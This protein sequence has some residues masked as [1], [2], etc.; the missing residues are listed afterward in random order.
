MFEAISDKVK[1]MTA[2]SGN[3]SKGF[4]LWIDGVGAWMAC[5]GEETTIGGPTF[6]KEPADIS[7]MANISRI[8][9]TIKRGGDS[10]SLEAHSKTQV[11]NRDIESKTTL[12]NDTTIKL[13]NAV[14]LGFRV[15]TA[16]S[17]TAVLDFVSEHRPAQSVD[18]IVL[19]H[20]NC[21]LGPGP[22][23]HIVCP[24]WPDTLVLFKRDGKWHCKSRMNLAVDGDIVTD[25]HEVKAGS[26][27]SG[28]ELRLRIEAL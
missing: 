21:L 8:H 2:D 5:L 23:N 9:T 4:M 17:A 3:T 12:R 7:L 6:D 20:E 14:E 27:I 1:A 28:D 19:I 26:I 11:G 15:P 25:S 16:L 13:G 18:G 24:D 10:W 22:E